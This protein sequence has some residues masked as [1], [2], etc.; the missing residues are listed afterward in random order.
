MLKLLYESNDGKIKDLAKLIF[1]FE[2][3]ASIRLH[4]YN[5]P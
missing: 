4:G 1:L 5:M 3:V 2:T